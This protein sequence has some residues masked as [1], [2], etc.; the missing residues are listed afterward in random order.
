MEGRNHLHDVSSRVEVQAWRD[1]NGV[2]SVLVCTAEG[3]LKRLIALK[4]EKEFSIPAKITRIEIPIAGT[5]QKE[6]WVEVYLQWDENEKWT[7]EFP[8]NKFELHT[9]V[10]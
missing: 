8:G 4:E 7:W 10:L 3:N 5:P 6:E 2:T 1:L 9:K